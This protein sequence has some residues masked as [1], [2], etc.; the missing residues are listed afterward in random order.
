MADL[1]ISLTLS[2]GASLGAFQ[3]GA[4]AALLV[5]FGHAR[6]EE[7]SD[8]R[9]DAIGGASAGSLVGLLTAFSLLE[10]ADGPRLLSTAWVEEVDLSMLEEGESKGPLSLD[11]VQDRFPDLL[12]EAECDPDKA[13]EGPLTLLVQLTGLRGLTYEIPGVRHDRPA[14]ASTFADWQRFELERLGG[15]EQIVEPE[16]T[17]PL[18][19]VIVS[20]SHPGAFPPRLLDRSAD[21]EEYEQQGIIDFPEE[22]K[23]WYTDGG[24]VQ[25]EPLGRVI[26]AAHEREDEDR[27][28]T[29]LN[30]VI[31][32]RSEEPDG[33]SRWGDPDADVGWVQ[34]LAR[35]LSI[36]PAQGLYE[37]MRRVERD[38][39]RLE[40]VDELIEA[41][42]PRVDEETAAKLAEVLERT[43]SDQAV[44]GPADGDGGEGS[45]DPAAVLREALETVSGVSGK[46]H[47]EIDLISPL[48]MASETGESVPELLAGEHLGD[49]SGFLDEELRRS[50]FTLGY[51]CSLIWARGALGSF[52]LDQGAVERSIEA[53][54]KGR[55]YDWEEVRRGSSESG[56]L[57]I[58][59]RLR[60]ARMAGR[61]VR[62]LK[63]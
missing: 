19:V 3:A 55:L 49:F 39:R 9:V 46:R 27:A 56:D 20:A 45:G 52:D 34:A 4:V 60:L 31:D 62:A 41:L 32:A 51:E 28:A 63:G 1:R 11:G 5:G 8:I 37:D 24:L 40:R 6:L 38:N 21:R 13:Q 23:L 29:H 35:A 7:D 15:V 44:A 48:V 30:L 25:S 50:D 36:F 18:D 12:R 58:R 43:R 53:I 2:G 47:V 42:A 26:A 22:G 17:A 33:A 10:G 14:A 16:G 57:P 59:S 61:A 54:E